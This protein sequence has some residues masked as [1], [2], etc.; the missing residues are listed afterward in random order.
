MTHRQILRTCLGLLALL[1]LLAGCVTPISSRPVVL[2]DGHL[3]YDVR[4]NGARKDISDCMN[5]AAR[6]CSGQY[7]VATQINE[8]TGGA[9]TP[10]PAGNG[11]GAVLVRG[12]QRTM[13]VECGPPPPSR[14]PVRWLERSSA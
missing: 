6:V 12:N 4:C 13:I 10:A 1:A 11:T 7:H 8:V 14:I 3:G 9:A 5:E 2:P